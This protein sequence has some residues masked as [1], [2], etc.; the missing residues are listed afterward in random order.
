MYT[1]PSVRPDRAVGEPSSRASHA[2][3]P[4]ALGTART[5]ALTESPGP[6]D[7]DQGTWL[8]T[9]SDLVLQLF[10]FVLVA[11]VL[12]GTSR[13][14]ARARISAPS[15]SLAPTTRGASVADA[16]PFPQ[17]VARPP[18]PRRDPPPA[19][20][21]EEPAVVQGATTTGVSHPSHPTAASND[22][23]QARLASIASYLEELTRV[24]GFGDAITLSLE[25]STL[26]L[27]IGETAG[28]ASGSA[29]LPPAA[30]ALLR[31]IG[32]VAATMPSYALDVSGHTDGVPIHTAEFPSNLELSLKRAARVAHALVE[33]SPGLRVRTFAKGFGEYRPVASNADDE[34]RKRNRR[35]EIRLVPL[36]RSGGE[37]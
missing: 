18:A 3:S 5:A 24:G 8:V 11:A 15:A 23:D 22:M 27:S 36:E 9:F 19:E 7:D 20:V 37:P 14:P 31:E 32:R 10:A 26:A 12:G 2:P 16:L 17:L 33:A 34:G 25:G 4:A 29:D 6:L 13:L 30:D 1:S 21:V 28:F 35:V